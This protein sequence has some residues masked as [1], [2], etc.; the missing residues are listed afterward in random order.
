MTEVTDLAVLVDDE[1]SFAGVTL[2]LSR[3][4]SLL[5]TQRRAGSR[6]RVLH[7]VVDLLTPRKKSKASV[8]KYNCSRI[9]VISSPSYK[10]SLYS[11]T[12][13]SLLPLGS[14]QVLLFQ[15]EPNEGD[16]LQQFIKLNGGY[17]GQAI[18][19][20]GLALVFSLVPLLYLLSPY[21]VTALLCI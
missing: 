11:D 9:K 16:S 7:D 10:V 2:L 6:L 21:C 19:T 20:T 1:L 4:V 8:L 14:I 5:P 18:N 3:G 17:S 12:T 13:N 15:F